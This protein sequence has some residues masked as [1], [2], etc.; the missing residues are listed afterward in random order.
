[1]PGGVEL[2]GNGF[3]MTRPVFLAVASETNE[4]LVMLLEQKLLRVSSF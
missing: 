2:A 1:M 3:S 4:R